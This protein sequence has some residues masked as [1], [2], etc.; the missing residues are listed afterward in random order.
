[1]RKYFILSLLILISSQSLFASAYGKVSSGNSLYKNNEY[2]KSL[3]NYREAQIAAPDS[4]IV[5]YNIGDALH[6]TGNYDESNAEYS[7]VLNSKNKLLRSKAYYNMGNNAFA[8][9]KRDE[10]LS[11]YKKCLELNPKDMDAKYNIEYI[12]TQNNMPKQKQ[13]NKD[14]K[15][16]KNNKDQKQQN[17]QSKDN[18]NDK[19]DKDKKNSMSK[20]DAQRILQYYDEQEKRGTD[21]R[22]MKTPEQPKT[23]EDW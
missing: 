17:S 7:K 16:D 4:P 11:Y 23:D 14:G 15:N 1:M 13:K 20:E 3:E 2:D 21:K 8:Q 12:L 6:K 5:Y 9:D 10:A 19:N 22:K 18:N